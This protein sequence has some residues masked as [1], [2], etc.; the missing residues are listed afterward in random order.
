MAKCPL[1]TLNH[2][3]RHQKSL[4]GLCRFY[5]CIS[6]SSDDQIQ[7]WLYSIYVHY[8]SSLSQ[9]RLGKQKIRE[10]CWNGN[11]I[12][13]A[14]K[15]VSQTRLIKLIDFKNLKSK[16]IHI[17]VFLQQETKDGPGTK[18][19]VLTKLQKGLFRTYCCHSYLPIVSCVPLQRNWV[20]TYF[21]PFLP[22]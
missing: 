16:N 18:N 13:L 6:S 5:F 12:H 1:K 11:M 8:M 19:L 3:M 22:S 2:A 20:S 15:G 9:D 17:L 14:R 4:S 10:F 7:L 21:F